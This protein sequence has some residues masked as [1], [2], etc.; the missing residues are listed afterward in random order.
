MWMPCEVTMKTPSIIFFARAAFALGL[1]AI[2]GCDDSSS[3]HELARAV[4]PNKRIEL[5][6]AEISTDATVPTPYQVFVVASGKAPSSE[7][8]IFK[9]DKS[10]QPHVEWV[11][12][13]T[14][15][16]QCTAGR[17]WHFQNFANVM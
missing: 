1:S 12:D 3:Y 10:T 8:L 11:D 14:A 2:A 13:T 5:V 7:Q 6:I 15:V 16:I 9:I 17:I 4:S